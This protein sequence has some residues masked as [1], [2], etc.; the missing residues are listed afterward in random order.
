M[1]RGTRR[2]N[3]LGSRA[4]IENSALCRRLTAAR[5]QGPEGQDIEISDTA[6]QRCQPP[7]HCPCGSLTTESRKG[8]RQGGCPT[9]F[10]KPIS[11]TGCASESSCRPSRLGASH[12]A[13]AG[14]ASQKSS[15]VFL[16]AQ[17]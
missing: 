4:S 16:L 2:T 12:S 7:I 3:R 17:F 9:A 6:R 11:I 13:A 1:F 10:G 5:N 14:S 15:P 8:S